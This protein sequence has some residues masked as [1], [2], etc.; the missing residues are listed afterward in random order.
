MAAEAIDAASRFCAGHFSEPA[1]EV[2]LMSAHPSARR[3]R[4]FCSCA[5]LGFTLVELLVVIGIIGLLISILIPTLAKARE[6]ARSVQCLSNIRQITNATIMFANDRGGW[7]PTCADKSIRR[8]DPPRNFP[9]MADSDPQITSPADWIVWNRKLDPFSGRVV[10]VPVMNI[11]YSSLTK[12]LGATV[13]YTTDQVEA[14]RTNEKLEAIFRCPSDNVASRSSEAD[15]SHGS[16][17]YSYAMNSMYSNPIRTVANT[18]DPGQNHP[19]GKRIDGTFNGKFGSIRNASEKVLF[20]CQDEKT[21]DDGSYTPAPF[22]W[23]DVNAT[24][25]IDVVSSRHQNKTKKA[26]SLMFR[27]ERYEDALGNVGFADGHAGIFGR[28]DAL[29]ARYSGNPNADPPG[30]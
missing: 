13:V 28:K 26:K 11:T 19:R 3:S 2:H 25:P 16:Y 24:L 15:T 8:F 4:T 30:F 9:A 22:G 6:A 10:S 17:R 1:A 23:V 14:N 18:Y 12:Y 27:N 21:L 7:M 29:R 5:G 20:V